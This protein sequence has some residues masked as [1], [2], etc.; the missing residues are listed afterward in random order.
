MRFPPWRAQFQIHLCE[1]AFI[2]QH[3]NGVERVAL[4]GGM[5]RHFRNIDGAD[6]RNGFGNA[7]FGV[8]FANPADEGFGGF[9][10]GSV[11]RR[12]ARDTRKPAQLFVAGRA[13]CVE[14]IRQDDRIGQPVRHAVL[15]AERMATPWT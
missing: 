4:L 10:V 11:W 14:K 15:T 13:V 5:M 3:G 6:L 8:C 9:R 1:T 2:H 7:H 12:D